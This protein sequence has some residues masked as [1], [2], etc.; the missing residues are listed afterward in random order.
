MFNIAETINK[1]LCFG[2][3][4]RSVRF[5]GDMKLSIRCIQLQQCIQCRTCIWVV[6]VDLL[7]DTV[8]RSSSIIFFIILM[9]AFSLLFDS[10]NLYLY[11]FFLSFSISFSLFRFSVAFY[12]SPPH[13]QTYDFI[14]ADIFRFVIF[15]EIAICDAHTYGCSSSYDN[16]QHGI[17]LGLKQQAL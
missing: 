15:H 13:F 6:F 10:L 14:F 17:V 16:G 7:I 4:M 12:V 11:L 5:V 9:P 2:C 8:F 1:L 3:L